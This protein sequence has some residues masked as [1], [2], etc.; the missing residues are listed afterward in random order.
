MSARIDWP[1]VLGPIISHGGLSERELGELESATFAHVRRAVRPRPGVSDDE[2]PFPVSPVAWFPRGRFVGDATDQPSNSLVRPGGFLQYAAGDY[3]IQD[4]GSMLALALCDI[5]P[6]EWVCDTCAAPGGKSTAILEEL[7]GRGVLISNE[8]IGSRLANLQLA[9]ARAGYNNHLVTNLEIELLQQ[10]CGR[11]FDKVLVD[12]PC[13]GQTL[14]ARGKQSIS[15]F[16]PVQIEHSRLRQ[17][18]ILRAAAGL[19][20]PSGSLVYSTCAYSFAENEQVILDFLA[21]SPDWQLKTMPGLEAWRSP[22]AEGCYR[23]WPH[24]DGCAGAFAALL[25]APTVFSNSEQGEKT[26][27]ELHGRRT[28]QMRATSEDETPEEIADWL[29]QTRAGQWW[30]HKYQLHHFTHEIP[31]EWIP[32]CVSGSCIA[33]CRNSRWSPQ[34]A[35]VTLKQAFHACNAIELSDAQALQ[36]VAG[37]AIRCESTFSDWCAV[38]WRGKSLS[39]GKM[40]Q[41]ILK[42]HFPKPLRQTNLTWS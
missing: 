29:E 34:L 38:Q 8:A 31:R 20:R 15:A 35:A 41:G 12:A 36:Y 13:T 2:L 10:L 17:Q 6:G 19:V 5:E 33:E 7:A 26:A 27:P 3:Y 37:A 4:A 11:T 23:V 28:W 21:Q 42:N 16:G 14:V 39:W 18:R 22:V 40:S 30:Q 1:S 24:R 25:V 32:H 9:L